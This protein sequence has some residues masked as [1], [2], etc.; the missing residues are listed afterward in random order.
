MKN[1]YHRLKK[2][3]IFLTLYSCICVF[4]L[5]SCLI[6]KQKT[7]A[8]Q[9]GEGDQAKI[10]FSVV[11]TNENWI[12]DMV[13]QLENTAESMD[14]ELIYETPE[15][16][17]FNW[18]QEQLYT[19]LEDN[20]EKVTCIIL[21]PAS[22]TGLEEILKKAQKKGIE[23]ILVTNGAER[24]PEC[25][26]S[27]DID[28]EQEG[29]LCAEF[30]KEYF[31]DRSANIIEIRESSFSN[32]SNL[33]SAGFERELGEH[34][35]LKIVEKGHGGGS[36]LSAKS[37]MEDMIRK[38]SCENCNAVFACS[39]EDGLGI[40]YALKLAGYHPGNDV[41]LVSASGSQ[42]ILKAIIAGEYTATVT[43]DRKLGEAICDG[44]RQ[45]FHTGK[46]VP[47]HI[48]L[49]PELI[50]RSTAEEYLKAHNHHEKTY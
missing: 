49:Q 43:S 44:I 21:F 12:S 7:E 38:G 41:L 27:I 3:W 29:A 32:T 24:H 8:L 35:N 33:R 4:F 15:E 9:G 17:T 10:L 14:M 26:L 45:I 19:Y 22:K 40:L 39:N 34:E 31:A 48:C 5:S 13:D 36:A 18:Q 23:V 28:Y 6:R 2:V 46:A 11:E 16:Y 25:A 50:D 1:N 42:D 47:S 20:N 37:V 30:L